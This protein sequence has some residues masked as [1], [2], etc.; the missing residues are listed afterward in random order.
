MLPF[1][2]NFGFVLI[3][4]IYKVVMVDPCLLS[5]ILKL[6]RTA[7]CLCFLYKLSPVYGWYFYA[8]GNQVLKKKNV[9]CFSRFG[10]FGNLKESVINSHSSFSGS[11]RNLSHFPFFFF[12]KFTIDIMTC[13]CM[14]YTSGR[15]TKCLP[16]YLS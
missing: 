8:Q 2:L 7:F 13:P 15:M 10:V 5:V 12:I 16:V 4:R 1:Y 6:Y 3:Y 14:Y 9:F 11:G